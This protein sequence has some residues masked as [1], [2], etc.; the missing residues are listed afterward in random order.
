MLQ[1][2]GYFQTNVKNKDE[3]HAKTDVAEVNGEVYLGLYVDDMLR[4]RIGLVK[5]HADNCI[6]MHAAVH[7]LVY[8]PF[9]GNMMSSYSLIHIE[10]H[11]EVCATVFRPAR[12]KLSRIW[13]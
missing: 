3:L 13:A 5:I 12:A 9:L 6:G 8:V 2:M 7:L 1:F 11:A 10:F 4:R